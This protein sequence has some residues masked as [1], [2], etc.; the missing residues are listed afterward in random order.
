MKCLV[1]TSLCALVIAPLIDITEAF[2]IHGRG[3][4]T[5]MKFNDSDITNNFEKRGSG[6]GTWYTGSDLKNAACYGRKGFSEFTPK[7]NDMIGAMKM[8]G[9]FEYCYKC[10]KVTNNKNKKTVTVKIVD[11]CAGCDNNNAVDL[12]PA[13]FKKLES[14]LGKGILDISWKVVDCPGDIEDIGPQKKSNDD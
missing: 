11:Q 7:S 5:I 3:V 13:A 14:D 8:N 10:M 9:G 6:R 1:Y 4:A 2:N 12:T